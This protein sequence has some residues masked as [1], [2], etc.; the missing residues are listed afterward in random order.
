MEIPFHFMQH[1]TLDYHKYDSL[2]KSPVT[3]HRIASTQGIATKT[4]GEI[5]KKQSLTLRMCLQTY[6]SRVRTCALCHSIYSPH[7]H[8]YGNMSF[9][10]INV[11]VWLN[12]RGSNIRSSLHN[13]MHAFFLG[14]LFYLPFLFFLFCYITIMTLLYVWC[15]AL[16]HGAMNAN[17]W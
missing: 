6:M 4:G 7:L 11:C 3:L 16:V 14:D 2:Y 10:Q 8:I 5:K 15:N 9:I 12:F 13:T 17:L 1:I